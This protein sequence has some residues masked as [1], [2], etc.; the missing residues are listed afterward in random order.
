MP[1]N[2]K[3]VFVLFFISI[4][5]LTG[6][7]NKENRTI[8]LKNDYTNDERNE[9]LIED[10]NY[11]KT[12]LTNKHNNPFHNITKEEFNKKFDYLIKQ[13]DKLTNKQVFAEMNKIVASIGDAHTGMNYWDGYKYPLKFYC[14]NDEIYVINADKSLSDILYTKVIS[15]NG[16][17]IHIIVDKL[18]ELIPHENDSWVAAQL[19]NYL[20]TPVFMYGLGLIPDEVKTSFEFEFSNGNIIKREIDILYHEEN[21]DYVV[22]NNERNVYFFEEENEDYYWY[23]YLNNDK[24]LYFK[25][26]VCANMQKE[27]FN[28]F[29]TKMFESIQDK[30]I[31]NFIIDLRHNSGGNSSVINP[32]L[33]SI[34]KLSSDKPEMDIFI[35]TGRDTF[36]SGV[37]AVLDI[38]ERVPVTLIGENT[39]GSP[40]SYGEVVTFELPNSKLPIYYSSKYF[41]LTNDG[42]DT[43]IPDIIITHTIYDYINNK[44][45]IM[46]YILKISGD[47]SSNQ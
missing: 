2:K 29:N 31:E 16:T 40:N 26:N 25:Y 32:F 3:I 12:Q 5:I 30:E 38:K 10:I 21:P 45:L 19:P 41:G 46:D 39:G 17:D 28:T 8:I 24:I 23:E 15:I 6:C 27:N 36:S 35:I 7:N 11:L 43:I 47:K 44:D 22:E 1:T 9:L 14:F 4:I 13:V 42:A 20:L 34:S 18:K 37:M 33:N